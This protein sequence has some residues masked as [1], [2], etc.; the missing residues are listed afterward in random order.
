MAHISPAAVWSSVEAASSL[1]TP[2]CATEVIG[3]VLARLDA[4]LA[5]QCSTCV[6]TQLLLLSGCLPQLVT[7]RAS[8]LMSPMCA[9]VVAV[10]VV[11]AVTHRRH[12]VMS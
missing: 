1:L 6:S 4:A 5:A 11:V 10:A 7:A 8:L 12:V 2:A 9:D 3:L